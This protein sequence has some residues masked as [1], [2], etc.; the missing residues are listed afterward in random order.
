MYACCHTDL[1]S[2]CRYQG[3]RKQEEENISESFFNII[4]TFT[5]LRSLLIPS[6]LALNPLDV[7]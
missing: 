5:F 4:Y 3:D 6:R 1:S 7:L 2:E